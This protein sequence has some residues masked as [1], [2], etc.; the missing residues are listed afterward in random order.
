MRTKYST[1]KIDQELK[2]LDLITAEII[3]NVCKK[4]KSVFTSSFAFTMFE[5][6]FYQKNKMTYFNSMVSLDEWMSDKNMLSQIELKIG[7]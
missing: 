2:T 4:H 7:C 1:F 3:I 6:W 5:K